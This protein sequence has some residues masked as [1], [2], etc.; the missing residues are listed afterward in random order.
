M[1]C[2]LPLPPLFPTPSL[3]PVPVPGGGDGTWHDDDDDNDD[4]YRGRSR[5]EDPRRPPS[6]P[7]HAAFR[8]GDLGHEHTI[9][10][11]AK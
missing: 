9:L 11:V 6:V 3:V 10:V 5:H 1:V 4:D 2:T 7:H 8:R